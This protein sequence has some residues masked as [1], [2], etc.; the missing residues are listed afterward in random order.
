MEEVLDASL[1][2]ETADTLVE[3]LVAAGY[4]EEDAEEDAKQKVV[5]EFTLTKK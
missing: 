5:F 4:T 1:D 2:E 3:L